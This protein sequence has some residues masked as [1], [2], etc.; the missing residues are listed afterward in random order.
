[1]IYSASGSV[2]AGGPTYPAW[3]DYL[4]A[5]DRRTGPPG[6]ALWVARLA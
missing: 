2:R 3:A 6:G 5:S 1:M 4:D